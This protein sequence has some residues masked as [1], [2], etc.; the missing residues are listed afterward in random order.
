MRKGKA[1][2]LMM[3]HKQRVHKCIAYTAIFTSACM[4]GLILASI[5]LIVQV[6]YCR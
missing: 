2:Q 5:I 6:E 1:K 4:L 3:K